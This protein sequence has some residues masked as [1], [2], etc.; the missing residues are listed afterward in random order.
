MWYA[1]PTGKKKPRFL[2]RGWPDLALKILGVDVVGGIHQGYNHD[3]IKYVFH[4]ILHL[5][6][7]GTTHVKQQL[8]TKPIESQ[9]LFVRPDVPVPVVTVAGMMMH[10]RFVFVILTGI[11]NSRGGMRELQDDSQQKAD[12][13]NSFHCQSQIKPRRIRP[14]PVLFS[15]N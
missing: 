4:S 13:F 14:G 2:G 6:L 8:T 5:T 7:I 11:D 1:L 9:D 15:L 3:C 12:K 10:P